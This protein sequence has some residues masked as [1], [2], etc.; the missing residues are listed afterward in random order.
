MRDTHLTRTLLSRGLR[1]V[2]FARLVGVDKGTV[3]RWSASR[4]PAERVIDIEA[5]TSIPRSDLRP[6][7]YPPAANDRSTS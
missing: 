1:L 6:D 2:E 3:S 5:A 4:I 7:L